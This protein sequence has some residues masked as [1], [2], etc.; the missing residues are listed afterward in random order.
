MNPT[1]DADRRA[2]P[3]DRR[4][5]DFPG[6]DKRPVPIS[7]RA[8]WILGAVSFAAIIFL[9]T[10]FTYQLDDIKVTLQHALS[11]IVG[12]LLAIAAV[13]GHTRPVHPWIALSLL[14]YVLLGLLSTLLA[15]YRWV[16]WQEWGFELALM[17]AFAA[18]ALTARTVG[19]FKNFCRFYFA[20]AGV[21][22]AFGLF[23]Y[24]GGISWLFHRLY[25]SGASPD[26][27]SSPLFILLMTLDANREMLST[28]LNRDFYPAYLIMIV[29]LAAAF[30]LDSRRPLGRL[31]YAVAGLFCCLCIILA[32]SNDSYI[33]LTIMFALFLALLTVGG[34]WKAIP[35]PVLWVWAVGGA[36]LI[37]TTLLSLRSHLSHVR[38]QIPYAFRSRAI[39][40]SG[41]LGIFFDPSQP[42]AIFLRRMI[43]GSGPGGYLVLLPHY[44]SPDYYRWAIAPITQFSHSQPFDLLSEHGLLGTVAFAALLGGIA[45]LLARE[46]RRHRPKS[47]TTP[48]IAVYQI[49][50]FTAVMG[51]SIQ[52]LTSPNIRW[53]ACGFNYWFLLGLATAAIGMG[54][55]A[56]ERER[57]EQTWALRPPI[58]RFAALS[59]LMAMGVFALV[60][61]PFGVR[62]FV[63]AKYNNDA[64]IKV[65]A[66]A[67]L[68][69]QMNAE[70]AGANRETLRR[71]ALL[72]LRA[73][74]ADLDRSIR[75]LPIF[76]SS[77]YLFG[78]VY[79]HEAALEVDAAQIERARRNAIQGYDRLSAYAPDYAEI[80]VGYGM[81]YQHAYAGTKQPADREQA[82]AH[83]ERAA[84]LCSSLDTQMVYA[85][86]LAA[87]GQLERARTV[88]RRILDL[89]RNAAGEAD[90]A[91]VQEA[92]TELLTDARSRNDSKELAALLRWRLEQQPLD[93]AAFVELIEALRR[94]GRDFAALDLCRDWI[95]RG[96][97]DPLPRNVAARIL[98]DHGAREKALD[99]V[100]AIVQLQEHRRPH[101]GGPWV[102]PPG[103]SRVGELRRPPL[104]E[105]WLL[106]GQIAEELGQTSEA[107]A[108]Y[109]RSVG[110]AKDSKIAWRARQAFDSLQARQATAKRT[111][112]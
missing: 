26:S 101:E 81:I 34:H 65:N 29:P 12:T 32:R 20:I 37:A 69:G 17:A 72:F 1:A 42:P 30:F 93:A 19:Q 106:A 21:T 86:A 39:L 103:P 4:P 89:S 78:H 31:F 96:P 109:G 108:C 56:A 41:A 48:G 87:M 112:L 111:G 63:A 43:L 83:F 25:P 61:V 50:L 77:Y 18:P 57:L 45:T 66:V 100:H 70:P 15:D 51:I 60:S 46:I 68:V 110:V 10:P 22:V 75:W 90:N 8:A 92:F 95:E 3:T 11:P 52:N 97:F 2:P 102:A 104:E 73:A 9:F 94:L 33:A 62:R 24:F 47:E 13:R 38:G 28:I 23:H 54:R 79:S 58:R 88:Y 55:P 64:R 67:T 91:I 71:Q 16:G 107:L 85:R 36:V 35:R 5:V 59:F 7:V 105:L 98:L 14:A 49:A 82:I 80:H 84:R 76:I 74:Q 44:Q 99:Q 27:P 40:W 53:T 6:A